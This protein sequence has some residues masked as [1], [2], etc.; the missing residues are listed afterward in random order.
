MR[1]DPRLDGVY[2]PLITPFRHDGEVALDALERLGHEALD[3]GATGLVALGTT[4]EPATLTQAERTAEVD[5]CARVCGERDAPLLVGAGGNDTARAVEAVAELARWPAVTA[6]LCVVPPYTRP[7]ADGIVRHFQRI[8]QAGAVPLVVYN[9]P[10]RTGRYLGSAAMRRLA[11]SPGI[12][13]VKHAAGGIDQ[14]TVELMRDLPPGFS[15]LCGDD[16]FLFPMLCLGAR[17]GILASAHL[18][19]GLFAELVGRTGKGDLDTARELAA[20]LGPLAVALFAEP[21]PSVVKG[22]L[23]AQGRIPTPDLR[24][25]MTAASPEGVDRALAALETATRAA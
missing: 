16:V 25:P 20:R 15:V 8:A 17:G 22:V 23:H 18:A 1:S 10:Y 13:G 6:T 14:D 19:T 9:I 7:S 21:N 4:G 11:G 2:V 12:A 3:H 24:L 5:V